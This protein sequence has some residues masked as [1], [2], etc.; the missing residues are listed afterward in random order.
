MDAVQDNLVG[1]ITKYYVASPPRVTKQSA[2][3]VGL[4]SILRPAVLIFT[5]LLEWKGSAPICALTPWGHADCP[6]NTQELTY[7]KHGA[8]GESECQVLQGFKSLCCSQPPPYKN[9]NWQR[10]DNSWNLG[11]PL[12]CATR[13]P[14]GK[15]PIATDNEGC[16]SGASLFCCDAPTASVRPPLLHHNV[17]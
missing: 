8:G 4:H 7:S 14:P 9:C 1:S 17:P 6:A 3:V 16:V 10:H 15:T 11:F 12:F 2:N 5:S 13:C